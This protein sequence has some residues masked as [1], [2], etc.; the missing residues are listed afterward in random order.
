MGG[1][2][3]SSFFIV[4]SILGEMSY[5]GS[6]QKILHYTLYFTFILLVVNNGLIFR[7]K[8]LAPE[9]V[10]NET[11][12]LKSDILNYISLYPYFNKYNM[13]EQGAYLFHKLISN[14]L[15]DKASGKLNMEKIKYLYPDI[16]REACMPERKLYEFQPSD[17]KI[18]PITNE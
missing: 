15:V 14:G 13:K 6:F 8:Y 17:N 2:F 9:S 10:Y 18:F 7:D 4:L 5:M 16:A 1:V 3:A 12:L 11:Y